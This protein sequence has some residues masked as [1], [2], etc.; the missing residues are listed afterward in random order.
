MRTVRQVASPKVG[1]G[2]TR[3]QIQWPVHRR[4]SCQHVLECGKN[5]P[6]GTGAIEIDVEE[7][8]AW[9]DGESVPARCQG[10]EALLITTLCWEEESA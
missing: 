9:S 1:A 7:V 3:A 4:R 8:V 5:S 10:D 2:G 6:F